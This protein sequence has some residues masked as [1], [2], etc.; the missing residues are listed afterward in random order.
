MI[1]WESEE[2]FLY[3]YLIIC[4]ISLYNFILL[5]LKMFNSS[6][7]VHYVCCY[8]NMLLNDAQLYQIRM[9]LLADLQYLR[10]CTSSAFC[11]KH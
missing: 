8:Q 3:M 10:K 6:I 5:K 9:Q 7:I 11:V 2:V 4:V 1:S